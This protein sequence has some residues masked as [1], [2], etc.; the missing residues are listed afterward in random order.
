MV[1]YNKAVSKFTA[2][3]IVLLFGHKLG[4]HF[5]SVLVLKCNHGQFATYPPPHTHTLMFTNKALNVPCFPE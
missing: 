3:E 2:C 5:L 4:R 1:F